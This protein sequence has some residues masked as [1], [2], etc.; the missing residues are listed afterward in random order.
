MAAGAFIALHLMLFA[1][2]AAGSIMRSIVTFTGLVIALFWHMVPFQQR[3]QR[4]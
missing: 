2:I 1:T 4:L 3:R